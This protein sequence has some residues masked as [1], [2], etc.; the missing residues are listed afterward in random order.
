MKL[1]NKFLWVVLPFLALS[2]LECSNASE[3]GGPDKPDNKITI[4][5]NGDLTPEKIDAIKSA[6]VS[7][8]EYADTSS[9]LDGWGNVNVSGSVN[10]SG[11]YHVDVDKDGIPVAGFVDVGTIYI[12][13]SGGDVD[14]TI[15]V[16]L[17]GLE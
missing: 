8:Q 1:S 17:P 2:S 13:A 3:Q 16:D 10:N 6:L 14:T 11:Q 5:F 7:V 15:T 12:D 9:R 4:T